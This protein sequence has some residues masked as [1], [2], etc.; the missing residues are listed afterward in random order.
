MTLKPLDGPFIDPRQF[1]K[2][3]ELFAELYDKV[4]NEQPVTCAVSGKEIPPVMPPEILV[5]DVST[6][7]TF[8]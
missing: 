6:L 2:Y 5:M 4:V 8:R 1:F 3:M 7:H